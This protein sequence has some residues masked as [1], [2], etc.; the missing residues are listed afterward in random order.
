MLG[1]LGW[2]VKLINRNMREFR[3]WRQRLTTRDYVDTEV[4]LAIK[5]MQMFVEDQMELLRTS[6]EKV[7]RENSR[8]G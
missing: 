6:L 4:A 8:K 2:L 1:L 7:L 3:A 5:Q